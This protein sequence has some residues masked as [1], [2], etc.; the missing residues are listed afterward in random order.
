M[1]ECIHII[2]SDGIG[3]VEAAARSFIFSDHANDAAKLKIMYI[4]GNPDLTK[5]S[6]DKKDKIIE[7]SFS[8]VNNPLAYLVALVNIIKQR[9]KILICSLWRTMLIGVCYK[10][11][12]PRS[13]LVC[14]LHNTTSLHPLDKILINLA[15]LF[16]DAIWSDSFKTLEQRIPGF[17][18]KIKKQRAISFV[19]ENYIS[20]SFP[21]NSPN[22]VFWGRLN[23]QKGIDRALHLFAALA[24]KNPE[25]QY[26]IYGPDDGE[27][28]KLKS[29]C[30]EL[31]LTERVKFMGT[32]SFEELKE[33]S[34]NF[35]YYLQFSR[36]EGMAISVVEAMQLGIVPIVSPVGEI[37][38]YCNRENAIIVEEPSEV[39]SNVVAISS[40]LTDHD[41]YRQL[42]LNA[43]RKWENTVTYGSDILNALQELQI[44]RLPASQEN[45]WT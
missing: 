43:V 25:V 34:I 6:T 31:G 11:L 28:T 9:P 5:L 39:E 17:L 41:R 33:K 3:G 2:P 38:N 45:K 40:I 16:S 29:L 20:K 26:L 42:Q 22:F 18:K 37:I 24:K 1:S 30:T 27:E 4:A 23:Y 14:F 7:S 36:Y 15:M 32:T 19:L 13:K 12:Y 8:N 35:S 44:T 21:K 10:I